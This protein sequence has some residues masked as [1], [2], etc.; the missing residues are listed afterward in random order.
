MHKHKPCANAEYLQ[1]H[2][3]QGEFGP[4]EKQQNDS[5]QS[6]ILIGSIK[7]MI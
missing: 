4:N 1:A 6:L 2:Q 3:I 7:T 5:V